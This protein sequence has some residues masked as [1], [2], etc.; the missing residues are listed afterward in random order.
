MITN[1]TFIEEKKPTANEIFIYTLKK[2]EN[3][4]KI[5]K[6]SVVELWKDGYSIRINN[7]NDKTKHI[8]AEKHIK[9][10]VCL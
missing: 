1:L 9:N 3:K 4:N 6:L 10:Q 7:M 8:N 5:V 2:C